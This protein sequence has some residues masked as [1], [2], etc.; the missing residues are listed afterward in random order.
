MSYSQ[1]SQHFGRQYCKTPNTYSKCEILLIRVYTG[2]GVRTMGAVQ[3]ESE[4]HK[5]YPMCVLY[6]VWY[7]LLVQDMKA[8]LSC[9]WRLCIVHMYQRG[10]LVR[11]PWYTLLIVVNNVDI[12]RTY[13]SYSIRVYQVPGTYTS[14]AV[15]CCCSSNTGVP[16][17]PSGIIP[18]QTQGTHDTRT[19]NHRQMIACGCK[20]NT[21][22]KQ[23]DT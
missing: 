7:K 19:V 9:V 14:T 4:N 8:T 16:V 23:N 1:Y 6:Q 5:V 2:H 15:I 21:T 20:T 22:T 10:I 12:A 13:D 3:S 17:V 11:Y 18:V